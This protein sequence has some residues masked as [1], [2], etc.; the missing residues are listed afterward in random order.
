MKIKKE[1][2]MKVRARRASNKHTRDLQQ[3]GLGM[4]KLSLIVQPKIPD[5]KRYV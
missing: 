4:L 3:R 2:K 5:V 1:N